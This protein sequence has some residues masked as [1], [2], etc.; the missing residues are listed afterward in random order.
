MSD[1][2]DFSSLDDQFVI[3]MVLNILRN[4]NTEERHIDKPL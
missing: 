2:S 3:F 1:I 4:E